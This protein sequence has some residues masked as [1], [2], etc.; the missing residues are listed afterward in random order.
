M[1]H[2]DTCIPSS[3]NFG[4]ADGTWVR[5]WDESAT[6]ATMEFKVDEP[7]SRDEP[8]AAK[9]KKDKEK[10]RMKGRYLPSLACERHSDSVHLATMDKSSVTAEA[11]AL[12]VSDK[13]LTLSFSKVGSSGKTAGMKLQSMLLHIILYSL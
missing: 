6:V 9:E 4:G 7:Q 8:A 1:Y 3:S 10:K 5:Y 12:P 2:D 11:S 13:P